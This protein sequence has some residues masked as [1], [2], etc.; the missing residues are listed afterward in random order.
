[1]LHEL[2][3]FSPA[4]LA[5]APPVLALAVTAGGVAFWLVGGRFS[6]SILTLALVAAGAWVGVRLPRWFGWEI[7]GMGLGMA[8]AMLLG[9]AGYLL[10][11]TWVGVLLGALTAA[12]AGAAAWLALAPGVRWT[13]PPLAWNW[14]VPQLLRQIWQSLPPET[15]KVIP[16][17]TLGGLAGGIV[18]ALLCPKLSR[19]LA[20]DLLGVTLMVL[21][22]MPLVAAHQ[23]HWMKHL[24]AG[25]EQQVLAAIGLVL[26]G[27]AVQWKLTPATPR[28][29]V[30]PASVL[31]EASPVA[32]DRAPASPAPHPA[33][34]RFV[35]MQEVLA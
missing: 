3:A 30:I 25:A 26:A 7:D 17:T 16:L 21:V 9:L 35:Q 32:P 2:T 20:F 19:T 10:H 33:P 13:P 27:L 15:S 14:D 1:M 29:A 23:P 12:W 28:K 4:A 24:P 8:G 31:R 6:R 11:R 22:G 5:D 34:R 18:T